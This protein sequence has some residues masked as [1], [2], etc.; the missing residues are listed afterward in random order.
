[1]I[2]CGP[3]LFLK[4][5]IRF[6]S[7]LFEYAFDNSICV[8]LYHM[9]Y[10]GTYK[11]KF[12]DWPDEA[13]WLHWHARQAAGWLE[14]LCGHAEWERSEEAV[15]LRFS[16]HFKCRA[17]RRADTLG[18][19]FCISLGAHRENES[20]SWVAV[21][22]KQSTRPLVGLKNKWI[23]Y[24]LSIRRDCSYCKSLQ[25][26]KSWQQGRHE[27]RYLLFVCFAE[28]MRA[29]GKYKNKIIKHIRNV[30]NRSIWHHY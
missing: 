20:S 13:E 10:M 25:I 26:Y 23:Y 16:F 18:V 2:C 3:I 4:C 12:F 27:E 28:D 5:F 24:L 21:P 15:H 30:T 22:G 14:R 6:Y 9:V 17:E 8:F 1:M 29:C 7:C 19:C 11:G